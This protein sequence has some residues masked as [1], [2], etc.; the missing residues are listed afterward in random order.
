MDIVQPVAESYAEMHSSAVDSLADKVFDYTVSHHPK[1][2]MISSRPQGK[3][4]QFF[5]MAVRPRRILEIGTF[6]GFSALCL[7]AGLPD[8]GQLHTVE[9]REDT[10]ATARANFNHS[11]YKDKI[12]LHISNALELIPGLNE[13]WDL[14]FIDAD[15]T[16]YIDYY[17]MV[18]PGMK[19]GGW[20]LADNVLYHGEVLEQQ[21]SGKNARAIAAF[22]AHV[23]ADPRTEQLV[24]TIRD[25]LMMIRIK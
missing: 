24:L 14:V 21:V 17:E 20:I 6:T 8:D 18:V 11:I 22:N 12:I 3:F 5:S 1:S 15:K 4:L 19:S 10:A 7:A 23:M 25:G 2:H 16:G 13:T 9:L